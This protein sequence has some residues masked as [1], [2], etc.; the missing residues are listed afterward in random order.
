MA[1]EKKQLRTIDPPFVAVGPMGVALRD[2]LKHLTPKDE[3]VLRLVGEHQG[4]LASVDLKARC[5]AGHQHDND[6]WAS[7]KRDLTGQSS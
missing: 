6:A 5:E 1:D 4:R 2:R 3:Q 7:R